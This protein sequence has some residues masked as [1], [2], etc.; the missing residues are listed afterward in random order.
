MS[1]RIFTVESTSCDDDPDTTD[2]FRIILTSLNLLGV[3][4][5]GPSNG[6]TIFRRSVIAY[7]SVAAFYIHYVAFAH[8]YSLCSGVRGWTDIITSF[9]ACSSVFTLDSLSL[10]RERMECLLL[11]MRTCL[12]E[13]SVKARWAV[14]RK[15]RVCTVCIWAYL[16]AFIVN[17]ICSMTLSSPQSSWD[18]YL[19]GAN[20]SRV[21]E[22][23]AKAVALV[24]TTLRLYLV[25]G[26]WFFVMALFV[27]SCW[28]LRASFRDLEEK[29]T[30]DMTAEDV[31]RLK[32]R[33]CQLTAV[34]NELDDN[35][36]PSLFVWYVAV[37]VALCSRFSAIVTRTSH[38]VQVFWWLTHL[39]GLLWT[40][41][42]LFGVSVAAA[43]INE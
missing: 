5:L 35:L 26:P 6:G 43:A 1:S 22:R 33:Y 19:L 18:S 34:V 40:L 10:R 11:S 16:A 36:S 27:L 2:P 12:A 14:L 39:L 25:D 32:E 8:L 20:A 7:R 3:F 13:G 15:S 30:E 17:S 42:I 41:A 29:V 37:L 23:K 31:S 28:V 4:S 24:A 9:I 21:S 38:E